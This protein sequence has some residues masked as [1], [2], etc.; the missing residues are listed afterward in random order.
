MTVFFSSILIM[1][2]IGLR[3][4]LQERKDISCILIDMVM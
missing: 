2:Q 4:F 3:E 1:L